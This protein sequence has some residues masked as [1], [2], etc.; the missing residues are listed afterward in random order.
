ML[1]G[2]DF[3]T[4]D[5]YLDHMMRDLDHKRRMVDELGG[6]MTQPDLPPEVRTQ[7]EGDLKRAQGELAGAVG[8]VAGRVVSQEMDIATPAAAEVTQVLNHSLGA[9]RDNEARVALD[10]RLTTIE[11]QARG[12]QRDLVGNLR[13]VGGFAR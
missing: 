6:L 12:G 2:K 8:N 10:E 13:K 9:I 7:V 1:P 5:L 3:D 4:G 11:T